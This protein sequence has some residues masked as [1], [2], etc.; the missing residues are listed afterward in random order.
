MSA[1]N[2]NKACRCPIYSK[3]RNPILEYSIQ[4]QVVRAVFKS[5]QGPSR[6]E[7]VLYYLFYLSTAIF[8]QEEPRPMKKRQSSIAEL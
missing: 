1:T 6:Y 7:T 4:S 3:T 8:Q 2:I 5:R